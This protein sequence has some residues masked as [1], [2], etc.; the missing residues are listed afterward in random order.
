MLEEEL[1]SRLASSLSHSRWLNTGKSYLLLYKSANH[2][3][4]EKQ[5]RTLHLIAKWVAWVYF[6]L[7]FTIKVQHQVVM[8]LTTCSHSPDS[9]DGRIP[10]LERPCGFLHHI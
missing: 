3:L 6:H 10:M 8:V 2:D 5:E 1:A 7:F 9:T 4:D